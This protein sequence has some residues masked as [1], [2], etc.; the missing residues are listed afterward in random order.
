MGAEDI[1]LMC[2]PKQPIAD[3]VQ[4]H[5]GS[6]PRPPGRIKSVAPD[7]ALRLPKAWESGLPT[8]WRE[9]AVNPDNPVCQAD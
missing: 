6:L 1:F 2:R 9:A 5:P 3:K 8:I 4:R 7:T